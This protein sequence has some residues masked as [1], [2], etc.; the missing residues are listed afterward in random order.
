MGSFKKLSYC[1]FVL[2]LSFLFADFED[3]RIH[4]LIAKKEYK[5]A[6]DFYLKE[7][8]VKGVHNPEIL[9]DLSKT[10]IEESIASADSREQMLGLYG[11]MMSNSNDIDYD[12]S[13]LISSKDPYVQ[14]LTIQYLSRWSEDL[15]ET[16][17]NKAMSS[18]FLQVRLLALGELVQIKS[19]LA[20]S[21]IESLYFRLPPVFRPIFANYYAALGTPH[22]LKILRQMLS[23][24]D[25]EMKVA[26]LLSICQFG[27]DDFKEDIR[28][29]LTQPDPQ[30]QESAIFASSVLHDLKTVDQ[31]KPFIQS[32]HSNLKLAALMGLTHFHDLS[33]NEKIFELALQGDLFAVFALGAIEGSDEILAKLSFHPDFN[34]RLNVLIGLMEKKHPLAKP[35]MLKFL[36]THSLYDGLAPNFSLGKTQ[37]CLKVFPAYVKQFEKSKEFAHY[38]RGMTQMIRQQLLIQSMELKESEFLEIAQFIFEHEILDL[39]PPLVHLLENYHSQET[40][41]MLKKMAQKV[42]SPRTRL[43]CLIALARLKSHAFYDQFFEWL[44]NQNHQSIIQL[45]AFDTQESN[46]KKGNRFFLTPDENSQLL[47]E[48]YETLVYLHD[49]KCFSILLNALVHAPKQNQPVL[50]GL[51]LKAL[52]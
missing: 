5:Q 37:N 49:E 1:S 6:I 12:F 27:R 51:I 28:R 39:I 38:V 22:S 33:Q 25:S 24:P 23:D 9:K 32:N 21:H 52:L 7:V 11:L 13:R 4:F 26:T 8:E 20:L 14:M 35:L 18:P 43:Y 47:I 29:I 46:N 36:S 10:I 41:D 44:K 17:L 16:W 15:I 34:V 2:S 3:Q 40:I 45:D 50:A 42:G 48:A 31:I 30:V 19:K